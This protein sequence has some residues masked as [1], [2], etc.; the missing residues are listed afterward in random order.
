[1]LFRKQRK[2]ILFPIQGY[3]FRSSNLIKSYPEDL[4][5]SLGEEFVQFTKLMRTDL[6]SHIGTKQ[7]IV[8]LQF[9]H[10]II[11]SSLESCFPNV[12]VALC[13]YLSFIV[14][15]YNRLNNLTQMSI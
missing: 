13:I 5:E 9:Y 10:L 4:E 2:P 3:D 1:M 6:P 8:E 11:D 7:D 15:N 14:N 12:E